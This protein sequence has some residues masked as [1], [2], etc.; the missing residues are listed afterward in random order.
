MPPHLQS[1]GWVSVNFLEL[2]SMYLLG[3]HAWWQH[4]RRLWLLPVG[5]TLALDLLQ[6]CKDLLHRFY[7]DQP[8]HLMAV[9]YVMRMHLHDPDAIYIHVG[10]FTPR[11]EERFSLGL[12]RRH[13]G[14]AGSGVKPRG[15]PSHIPALTWTN[16]VLDPAQEAVM[17]RALDFM[18][19]VVGEVRF[20]I[21]NWA[22]AAPVAVMA[23]GVDGGS[24]GGDGVDGDEEEGGEG[25]ALVLA[26]ANQLRL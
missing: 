11:S 15:V 13:I 8:L 24:G 26:L 16:N 23:A 20:T 7:P 9:D 19:A 18:A 14:G 17:E 5:S 22:L 4:N 25:A 1:N 3:R 2:V 12:L 6:L 21:A 10:P